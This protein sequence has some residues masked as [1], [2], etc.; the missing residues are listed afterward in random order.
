MSEVIN[1]NKFSERL[2]R[3]RLAKKLSVKELSKETNISPTTIYWWES[4]KSCARI[5]QVVIIA[6]YFD[7]KVDYL[8]GL[9]DE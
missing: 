9:K 1:I 3:L 7:V 4:G 5:V 6:D 2:K 8:I